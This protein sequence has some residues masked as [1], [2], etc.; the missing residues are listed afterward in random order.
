MPPGFSP[1]DH[2]YNRPHRP[3]QQLDPHQGA[4]TGA[5]ALWEN[6]PEGY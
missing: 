5:G 3:N 6:N 1:L 4:Q 2:V